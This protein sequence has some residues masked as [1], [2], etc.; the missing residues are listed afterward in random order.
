MK[1]IDSHN[2]LQHYGST[3]DKIIALSAERGC[4]TFLVNS[5]RMEEWEDVL[6]LAGRSDCRVVPFI[7]IHPWYA[8]AYGE[9]NPDPFILFEQSVRQNNCGIGEIGLDR[10]RQEVSLAEQVQVFQRQLG[11]AV[12]YD[13]PVT[14]HS[15]RAYNEVLTVLRG[16]PE[17]PRF[18]V[19]SFKGSPQLARNILDLGGFISFSFSLL[20]G[21]SEKVRELVRF[22]PL[23]ALFLESDSPDQALPPAVKLRPYGCCLPE[24]DAVANSPAAVVALYKLIAGIKGVDLKLLAD[25]I[26]ENFRVFVKDC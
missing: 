6:A 24:G 12:K 16:L 21:S 17:L 14:V 7:G 25:R 23:S 19:H 18:M 13:R 8:T 11:L 10:M 2:H 3:K 15:V 4:A 20:R 5:V 1:F 9:G 26:T 22:M